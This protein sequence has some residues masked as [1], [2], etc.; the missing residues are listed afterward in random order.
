MN[1]GHE[2]LGAGLLDT[3]SAYVAEPPEVMGSPAKKLPAYEQLLEQPDTVV[4]EIIHGKLVTQAR[5]AVR[6]ADATAGLIGE[7][8]GPFQRGRGGPGG[9]L[10]INEPELHLG[11]HVLVPDVAAWR[12]E[13]MPDISDAVHVDFRPDWV[14]EVLSPSTRAIDRA[15]KLPIY[16]THGVR[17]A[18]LVDPVSRTLE[19]YRLEVDRWLL[20]GTHRD[21]AVVRAE[22]FDAIELE[23]SALWER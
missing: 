15:D 6:H 13:G 17:H 7:L 3:A 8:R 10:V 14:C 1:T 12:R 4:A 16:A 9:W 11:P 19:V 22:P 23:L 21:D 2:Q 20:L 5:P 18:W